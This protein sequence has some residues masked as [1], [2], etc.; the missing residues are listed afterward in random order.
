MNVNKLKHKYLPTV[1][2]LLLVWTT[3]RISVINMAVT[4]QPYEKS[5]SIRQSKLQHAEKNI[6][7]IVKF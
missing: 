6:P 5:N 4:K 3:L 1:Y 7:L 2:Q